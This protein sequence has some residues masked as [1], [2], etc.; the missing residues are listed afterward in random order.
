MRVPVI[1]S[2][3]GIVVLQLRPYRFDVVKQGGSEFV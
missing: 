1:V 3:L 2:V